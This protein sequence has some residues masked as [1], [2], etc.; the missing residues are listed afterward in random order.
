MPLYVYDWK[1]GEVSLVQAPDKDAANLDVLDAL[2][3]AD[4]AD[5]KLVKDLA[6]SLYFDPVV[7][8]V[9]AAVERFESAGRT[10]GLLRNALNLPDTY[11]GVIAY[12]KPSPDTASEILDGKGSEDD[13]CE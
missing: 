5:I 6:T 9:V 13:N 11:E 12:P 4:T 2:G 8:R 7:S 1:D 3:S 10:N